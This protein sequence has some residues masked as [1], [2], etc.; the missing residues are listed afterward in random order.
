MGVKTT[1]PAVIAGTL[2]KL[3]EK[4][5]KQVQEATKANVYELAANA[6]RNTPKDLGKLAQGIQ[7]FDLKSPGIRFR[8]VATEKYSPYVEFGTGDQVEIPAGLED[9][10]KQFYVNGQ[11]HMPAQ[12]FL[13]P[14]FLRTRKQFLQDIKHI[15]NGKDTSR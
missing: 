10:A 7:V 12:P 6:K 3:T 15:I 13:Y 1:K 8:V 11:G 14:A 4:K 2:R 5:I 9:Y